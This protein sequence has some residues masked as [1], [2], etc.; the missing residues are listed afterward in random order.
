MRVAGCQGALVVIW[1]DYI[2]GYKHPVAVVDA[3]FYPDAIM[4]VF[5]KIN[6]HSTAIFAQLDADGRFRGQLLHGIG[7]S[8]NT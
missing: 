2:N 4:S 7:C 8:D 6:S 5:I 1:L 3:A